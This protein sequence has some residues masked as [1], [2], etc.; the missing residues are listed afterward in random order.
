MFTLVWIKKVGY[1]KRHTLERNRFGRQSLHLATSNTMRPVH[2]RSR[3]TRCLRRFATVSQVSRCPGRNHLY[4]RWQGWWGGRTMEQIISSANTQMQNVQSKRHLISVVLT[5]WSNGAI[6]LLSPYTQG[7]S[8]SSEN[9]P[10]SQKPPKGHKSI[11]N[12]LGALTH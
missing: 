6:S 9:P 11:Y 2:S 1:F 5:G 4:L 3:R 8:R 10:S 12:S 7:F